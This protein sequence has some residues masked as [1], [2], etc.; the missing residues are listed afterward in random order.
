MKIQTFVLLFSL[1]TMYL[2]TTIFAYITAPT[3]HQEIIYEGKAK[4]VSIGAVNNNL[5]QNI[6]LKNHEATREIELPAKSIKDL[7]END[8]VHMTV[9]YTVFPKDINK[10][11]KSDEG[12]NIEKP[13]KHLN[14]KYMKNIED[15]I[16]LKK[17]D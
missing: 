7:K 1:G 2:F 5:K 6:K 17:L 11:E 14:F 8:K 16:K 3:F 4:I 13:Q 9:T 15:N 12:I 10:T